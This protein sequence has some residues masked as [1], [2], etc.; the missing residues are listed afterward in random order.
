ME[1]SQPLCAVPLGWKGWLYQQH[2]SRDT[3]AVALLCSACIAMH[4]AVLSTRPG[5]GQGILWG[6]G[7]TDFYVRDMPAIPKNIPSLLAQWGEPAGAGIRGSG[8]SGSFGTQEWMGAL[9]GACTWAETQGDVRGLHGMEWGKNGLW[10]PSPLRPLQ[11]C[12]AS[13]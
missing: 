7:T 13:M 6:V 11:G 10:I 2:Y 9:R 1:G 3:V 12:L 5:Q 4:P 8:T